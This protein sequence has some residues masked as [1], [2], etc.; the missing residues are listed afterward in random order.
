LGAGFGAA[1]E[2]QVAD[3]RWVGVTKLSALDGET[4]DFFG[5]AVALSGR[6][7]VIGA[8]GDDDFAG[9][10]YVFDYQAD[11]DW[12]E[13]EKL[14]PSDGASGQDFGAAV[15]ISGDVIAVGACHD[16]D[17]GGAAGSVYVFE[18]EGGTNWV[19]TQKLLASDGTSGDNLGC[20]IAISQDTMIVGAHLNSDLDS[21]SGAVYVFEREP[22]GIW[23]ESQKLVASDGGFL[24]VFGTSL[25]VF[26]DTILVGA[27]GDDELGIQS[28][29]A[30]LFERHP[31]GVWYE[32]EKLLAPDGVAG[33]AFGESVAIYENTAAVGAHNDDHGGVGSGSV[34]LFERDSRGEWDSTRKLLAFGNEGAYLF[35]HSL[36]MNARAL[37]VGAPGSGV[38]DPR[39]GAAYIFERDPAGAWLETNRFAPFDGSPGDNFG[40]A[41]AISGRGAI[42]GSMFNDTDNGVSTGSTYVVSRAA[43]SRSP[44]R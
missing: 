6:T 10:A 39:P 42:I 40:T 9:A 15:A 18:S 38:D 22:N 11:G 25:A 2:A 16:D 31:D 35:G 36:A 21:F 1:T 8:W 27:S 14:L 24:H 44:I 4:S 5:H 26:G 37:I 41:V 32:T 33:D 29:S 43:P 12:V 3:P 20:A 23:L 28:G 30:Y 17:N 19:E 7:A 13:T 34:Y